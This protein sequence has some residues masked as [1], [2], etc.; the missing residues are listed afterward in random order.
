MPSLAAVSGALVRA[1]ER[2]TGVTYFPPPPG[3]TT[4]PHV[5][6]WEWDHWTHW[7]SLS[8]W[9]PAQI[10]QYRIDRET[11]GVGVPSLDKRGRPTDGPTRWL[12]LPTPKQVLLHNATAPN[13][14]WGGAAGDRKCRPSVGCVSGVSRCPGLPHL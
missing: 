3:S 11:Y 7:L 14:L 8:G 9:G 2:V 10:A 6:R 5:T 4:W 13:V 1:G 12:Y